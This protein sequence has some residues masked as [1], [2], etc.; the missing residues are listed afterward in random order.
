MTIKINDEVRDLL[1]RY[2]IALAKRHQ[3][4]YDYEKCGTMEGFREAVEADEDVE[5]IGAAL[6]ERARMEIVL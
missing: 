3:A 6:R 5:N 4:E 1:E 2:Y